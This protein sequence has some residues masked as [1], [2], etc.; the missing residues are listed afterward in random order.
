MRLL[1]AT[2]IGKRNF[3]LFICK[4]FAKSYADSSISNGGEREGGTRHMKRRLLRFGFD[5]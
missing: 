3:N 2:D 1:T 4:I 5:G